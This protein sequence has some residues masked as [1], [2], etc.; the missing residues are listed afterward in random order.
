MEVREID[1]SHSN[2]V[3]DYI[4][5][6]KNV[7]QLFD[8][9]LH[10][11]TSYEQRAEELKNRTFKRE[12]LVEHLLSTHRHLPYRDKVVENI[13]KLRDSNTMTIVGGQQA[14]LLTGPLFT[15]YKAISVIVLAKQQETRLSTP[16]VPVFWIA[17]EDHDL[18]EIRYVY[19]HKNNRWTKHVLK[20]KEQGAQAA[21]EINLSKDFLVKWI[22]DLFRT[23]PETTYTR[24][25]TETIR[26][27]A[28]CSTTYIDFFSQMMHWLF[29]EQ[30]L[31]LLDSNH[32]NLRRIESE[33]FKEIIRD[34]E[35]VQSGH[36]EG[37]RKYQSLGYGTP[38]E[39]EEENAHLF[40]Q[41][42]EERKRLDFSSDV[43]KVK[44]T[45]IQYLKGDL[46]GI[47]SN[48]PEKLSNNVVSRPIMQE[49][50]LPVL[51]FITG[52]GELAYWATL[53]PVFHSFNH[54][55][56]LVIPRLQMTYIPRHIDKWVEQFDFTCEQFLKG[57]GEQ[58]KETWLSDINE[59]PINDEIER[60]KTEFQ[61]SHRSIQEL[62][63][64]MDETLYKLSKKNYEKIE[65]QLTFLEK[66]M[67]HFVEERHALV[68]SKF[69][70]ANHCLFPL[71]RLQERVAH[72]ILLLN[73]IG[74]KGLSRIMEMNFELNGR[75]KVIIL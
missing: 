49:K 7:S 43:F 44:G 64:K 68:L 30:G 32:P 34:I 72:P 62:A 73:L 69:D 53:K 70:E 48:S 3:T 1:L 13:H 39:T 19:A 5:G 8:Y 55:M 60:V 17:G 26:S 23:L 67:N 24:S 21:S 46:L 10:E 71:N 63:M 9:S 2:I 41:V 37:L 75:H 47:A 52:P 16:I 61:Q 15:I 45:E 58:L 59:Y 36:I 22:D 50:L 12:E 38:I 29:K 25:L 4:E 18:E 6:N 28:E 51:G 65:H 40:I 20:Q 54:K 31:I 33:Y 27:F 11:P 66:K 42:N 35:A 14:G 56:P 57:Q 74:E